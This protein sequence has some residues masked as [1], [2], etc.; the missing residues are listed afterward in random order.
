[1]SII[2]YSANGLAQ[3]FD[4]GQ[5]DF[6]EH[7]DHVGNCTSQSNKRRDFGIQSKLQDFQPSLKDVTDEGQRFD[8]SR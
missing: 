4:S 1:M 8:T 5:Q 7:L 2:L 3:K 6:H